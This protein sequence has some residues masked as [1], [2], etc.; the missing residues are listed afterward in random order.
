MLFGREVVGVPPHVC[1]GET[2][3]DGFVERL[4]T[5]RVIPIKF[6]SCGLADQRRAAAPAVCGL[7]MLVPLKLPYRLVGYAEQ[8]ETPG[9]TTSGRTRLLPSAVTGPLDE[10][11]ASAVAELVAPT[12]K[13]SW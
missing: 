3:T 10:N 6:L 8:T 11:D 2:V 4:S 12:T 1:A 7:A 5:Q 13:A 9:A